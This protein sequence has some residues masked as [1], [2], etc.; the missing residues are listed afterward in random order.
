MQN[1]TQ[2]PPAPEGKRNSSVPSFK[3]SIQRCKNAYFKKYSQFNSS[4][5]NKLQEFRIMKN[6]IFSF[7]Y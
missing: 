1:Q 3:Q 7:F 6:K 2:N 4:Q 5:Y